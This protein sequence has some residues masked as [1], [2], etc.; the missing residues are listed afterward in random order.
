M[1]NN[2]MVTCK[3]V[4]LKSDMGPWVCLRWQLNPLRVTPTD[5]T[6]GFIFICVLQAISLQ[7]NIFQPSETIT[8]Q[9]LVIIS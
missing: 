1:K 6:L 5:G 7:T 9:V 4:I 2:M 8:E 3:A